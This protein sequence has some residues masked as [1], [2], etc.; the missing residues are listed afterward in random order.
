MAQPLNQQNLLFDEQQLTLQQQREM[1]SNKQ[2]H[3]A[4]SQ[5]LTERVKQSQVLR[6]CPQHDTLDYPSVLVNLQEMLSCVNET[7]GVV[8]LHLQSIGSIVPPGDARTALQSLAEMRAL[9]LVVTGVS[10]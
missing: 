7:L 2:K 3:H 8:Y 6:M 1:D 10:Q 9:L 5:A 4:Q